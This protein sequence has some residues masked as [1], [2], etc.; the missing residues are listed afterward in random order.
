MA[1]KESSQTPAQIAKAAQAAR[2]QARLSQ[3][4]KANMAR[5]KGQAR[6]RSAGNEESADTGSVQNTQ[7]KE[8]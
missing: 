7:N 8:T 1:D 4:L 2:K 5:R 3:A 6:A